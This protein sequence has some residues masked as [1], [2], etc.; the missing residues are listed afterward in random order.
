MP[1]QGFAPTVSQQENPSNL[2]SSR[3]TNNLESFLDYL[4][5]TFQPNI[6]ELEFKQQMEKFMSQWDDEIVWTEQPRFS[7]IPWDKS[8]STI[9]GAK[10]YHNAFEGGPV[11]KVWISLPGAVLHQFTAP[12]Q[13]FLLQQFNKRFQLKV[14]RVDVKLRDNSYRVSPFDLLVEGYNKRVK[15]CDGGSFAGEFSND[16]SDKDSLTAYFGSKQSEKFLRVYNAKGI[17]TDYDCLDFESQLRDEKAQT[18][19]QQYINLNTDNQTAVRFLGGVVVGCVE[20]VKDEFRNENLTKSIAAGARQ[21]WWQQL[22]DEVGLYQKLSPPKREHSLEKKMAWINRQVA[23]TLAAFRKAKGTQEFWEWLIEQLI[24]AEKRF[25]NVHRKIIKIAMRDENRDEPTRWVAKMAKVCTPESAHKLFN[26][27][28]QLSYD[29][30]KQILNMAEEVGASAKFWEVASTEKDTRSLPSKLA[31]HRWDLDKK[32]E[33]IVEKHC[34]DVDSKDSHVEL[35]EKLR[36][37]WILKND[38]S[39]QADN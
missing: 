5:A 34:K 35:V 9:R 16:D 20:F 19:W 23:P 21:D 31:M 37:S 32:V 8:A 22:I 14:N 10:I 7:G 27:I 28:C 36:P 30:Q 25:T 11:T 15:R 4:Q 39:E 13:H 17:H 24:D 33:A 6:P 26:E 29:L 2:A 38:S 18:F 1:P 12:H 3:I